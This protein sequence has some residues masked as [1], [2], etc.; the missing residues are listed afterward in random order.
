MFPIP[1]DWWDKY[2]R[3]VGRKEEGR[4]WGWQGVGEEKGE[5][6]RR[7][8]TIA[9]LVGRRTNDEQGKL[10]WAT[11]PM[12]AGRLLW[13]NTTFHSVVAFYHFGGINEKNISTFK[14][15]VFLLCPLL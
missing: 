8:V 3:T 7:N 9:L 5:N 10:G 13:A 15:D 4:V 1:I 11:K 12:N 6:W 2:D 14:A